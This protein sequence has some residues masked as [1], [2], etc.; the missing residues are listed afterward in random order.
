M[1]ERAAAQTGTSAWADTVAEV[2]SQNG[3]PLQFLELPEQSNESP[4]RNDELVLMRP[5]GI[6]ADRWLETASGDAV[7][8]LSKFLPTAGRMLR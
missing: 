6:I 5:D 2:A 1:G 4:W 3:F 7:E 8:R